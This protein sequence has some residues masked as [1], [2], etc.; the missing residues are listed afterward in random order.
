MRSVASIGFL[1]VLCV[2][3]DSASANAQRS[4][5]RIIVVDESGGVI[6]GAQLVLR[7]TQGAVLRQAYTAADGSAVVG[8]LPAGSYWLDVTA[9][10]FGVRRVGLN[11]GVDDAPPLRVVLSVGAIARDVTVTAQ[12]GMVAE[13]DRA[14]Q[15][16]TVREADELRR[17][18][19]PTIGH[20]LEGSPGV[21]LQ[22]SAYGQVSPF[23]RGLTGYQVLNL[24]DGVRFNNTTF[25]SGP[26]RYLAFVEPNQVQRIEAVLGPASAQFGS[27]A[28]GGAIQVLTPTPQFA[29]GRPIASQGEVSLFGGSADGS[30]GTLA[31][32]FVGGQ[33]ATGTVGGAWRKLDDVRAGDS[34]DSHHVLRRLFGLSDADIRRATG[35]QQPDTGFEQYGL[36]AKLAARVGRQQNL[37]LWYQRSE[38]ERVRGSKDLWGGLGRLRSDFEPQQLQLFYTR[39]EKVGV[40]RLDWVTGTFSINAQRDGSVRQGL[41]VTDRIVQ[42]KVAVDAFGYSVQAGFHATSRHAIVFGGEI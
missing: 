20:A 34:R 2:L 4:D 23:L 26:N 3:A 37:T 12:R 36:H 41:R 30:V 22:Q 40:G 35:D 7:S 42:D 18:A 6:P 39:Y 27:D 21:M 14:P 38:V 5:R 15:I 10:H 17:S 8:G 13:V 16:V 11:L 24:I 29:S 31:N 1:L 9:T 28:L 19:L 32:I 25:R 33:R